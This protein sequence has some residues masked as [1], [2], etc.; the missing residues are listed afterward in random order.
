MPRI[1]PRIET[2]LPARVTNIDHITSRPVLQLNR[3][4]IVAHYTGSKTKYHG[5]SISQVMKLILS[6]NRWKA[7]E[8]NYVIDWAGNIYEFAGEYR[9]AHAKGYNDTGYGVLFLNGVGEPM[10]DAQMAS[11]HFLFGCL[12]WAGRVQQRPMVVGHKELAA[13]ACPD[14]IFWRISEMREYS[15]EWHATA[16]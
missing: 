2:G 9:A 4:L 11:F 13:T 6:L 1:I 12:L 14:R 5:W 8:Y 16:A 10:T 3:G 7:N 15:P